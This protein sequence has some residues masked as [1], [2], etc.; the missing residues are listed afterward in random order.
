MAGLMKPETVIF[1]GAGA[2]R[3]LGLPLTDDILPGILRGL[4]Q[5]TLFGDDAASRTSLHRC[6][7]ALLPGLKVES[8]P[9]SSSDAKLLPPITDVIS[10]LDHLLQ[11]SNSPVPDLVL[12]DLVRGR[13]L[14]ERA[15]FEQLVRQESPKSLRLEGVPDAVLHEWGETAARHL[16]QP[17]TANDQVQLDLAVKWIDRLKDEGRVT[18]ISTNYDIEVE[19]ALYDRIG[20]K[21]LQTVDFGTSVRD[22]DSG[23]IYERPHDAALGIYKLHGSLNWLRCDVC[24]TIYVNPV[25][26]IAYLSFLL[27]QEPDPKAPADPMRQALWEGGANQCHCGHRPLRHVI[28]APSTV[29]DMRDVILVEIWRNAL[30]ALRRAK[31]WIIVGYSLPPEDVAIR[32][33]LLRARVGRDPNPPPDVIVV[34]KGNREPE[35]TRYGLLFPAHQYNA[36]GLEGY[37]ASTG[38]AVA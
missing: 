37:V 6:L 1:L 2:S 19:Q 7:T 31:T 27:E 15:I 13:T 8:A 33:V 11:T 10:T 21:A 22:P 12:A 14:L 5:N 9:A 30:A 35:L 3:A 16:F 36:G 24:D 26:P 28:V 18:V 17:R 25:G 38:D 34:Q 29:R 20:Y 23:D 4:H 32:S